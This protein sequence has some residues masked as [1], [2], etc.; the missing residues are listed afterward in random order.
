MKKINCK[1]KVNEEMNKVEAKIKEQNWGKLLMTKILNITF[2][3]S[4]YVAF[5][6]LIRYLRKKKT[7]QIGDLK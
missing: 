7:F 4:F 3:V 2:F 1:N 5:F 6:D